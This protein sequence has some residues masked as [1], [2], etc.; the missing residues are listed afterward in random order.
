MFASA[1]RCFLLIGSLFTTACATQS[2]PAAAPL[3]DARELSENPLEVT[4]LPQ[5]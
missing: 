2:G 1:L 3:P 4:D 5:P